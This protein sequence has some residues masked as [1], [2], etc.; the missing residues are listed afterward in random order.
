MRRV[1]CLTIVTAVLSSSVWAQTTN[2]VCEGVEKGPSKETTGTRAVRV[3]EAKREVIFDTAKGK[4][5]GVL[6]SKDLPGAFSF[7]ILHNETINGVPIR[8]ERA[9]IERSTGEIWSLYV[10]ESG[11]RHVVFLGTCTV[12]QR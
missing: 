6:E 2:F 11:S 3:D 5:S 12:S 10:A 4:R 7:R 1:L 8:M 9:S